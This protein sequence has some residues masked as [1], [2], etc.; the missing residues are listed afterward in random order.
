[1]LLLVILSRLGWI[2]LLFFFLLN[3]LCLKCLGVICV[4]LM[5][6]KVLL[7]C[8][9]YLCSS[10]VV[11]FLLMLVGLVISRWLLLFVICFSVVWIWLIVVLVLVNLFVMLLVFW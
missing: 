9:F 1:M 10:C 3:S 2:R 5:L 11:I 8:V 4:E 7:V 6:M